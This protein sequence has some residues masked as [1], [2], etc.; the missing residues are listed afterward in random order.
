MDMELVFEAWGRIADQGNCAVQTIIHA[1]KGSMGQARSI[2]DVRGGS[3]Q[4]G[5]L[6][7]ARLIVRMTDEEA[8]TLGIDPKQAS[9][10][11]RVGDAKANM[12]PASGDVSWMKLQSVFLDNA[13][14]DPDADN[15]Q[16]DNVQVVMPFR[17]P[18]LFEGVPWE[19]IDDMMRAFASSPR[20]AD[21]RSTDW[22]GHLVGEFLGI[23]TAQKAGVA[24]AKAMLR[25][26]IA[27]GALISVSEKDE[28]RR[29]RPHICLGKWEFGG[30]RRL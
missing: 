9:L 28:N 25:A 23:D 21:V 17:V 5:A 11:I 18:G 19:R 24:K 3:S 10:H 12:A 6:R 14:A 16:Q 1:R 22:S 15:D 20:R 4:L 8:A 27:T 13:S 26:W 29:D 30:G 2:E 7:D